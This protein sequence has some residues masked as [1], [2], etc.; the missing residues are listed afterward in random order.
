MAG[1]AVSS[2]DKA[3]KIVAEFFNA[4]ALPA[5]AVS[6]HRRGK[7]GVRI[8]QRR[9]DRTHV[10]KQQSRE[11]DGRG[12]SGLLPPSRWHLGKNRDGPRKMKNIC[13]V[14]TERGKGEIGRSE[15]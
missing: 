2:S 15:E 3:K 1:P 4:A 9:E 7:H 14:K 12:V 10:S 13:L 5:D 6:H 11:G 8:E